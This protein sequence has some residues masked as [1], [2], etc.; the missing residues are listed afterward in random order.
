MSI[1]VDGALT[2]L[3]SRA[4]AGRGV[5]PAARHRVAVECAVTGP[6]AD[7]VVVWVDGI[8]ALDHFTTAGSLFGFDRSAVYAIG[9][10]KRF[11][12]AFD[13]VVLSGGLAYAPSTSAADDRVAGRP[14]SAYR[15]SDPF[16]AQWACVRRT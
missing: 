9:D 7:R 5:L 16:D 10:S 8:L 4:A 13:D 1:S 11:D 15:S 12:V 14:A 6:D 2:E 3:A